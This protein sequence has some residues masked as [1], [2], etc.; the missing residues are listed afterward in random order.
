MYF[1]PKEELHIFLELEEIIQHFFWMPGWVKFAIL[2]R[3]AGKNVWGSHERVFDE[4][5][6]VDGGEMG[7][8]QEVMAVWR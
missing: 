7:G 6:Q 3:M 4:G 2:Q 1:N 8:K 5:S